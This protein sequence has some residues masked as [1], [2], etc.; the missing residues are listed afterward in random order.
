M[1]VL[2]FLERFL[3]TGGNDSEYYQ[4]LRAAISGAV[5]NDDDVAPTLSRFDGL[6]N[7]VYIMQTPNDNAHNQPSR[8]HQN[9]NLQQEQISQDLPRSPSSQSMT[10]NESVV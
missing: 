8:S 10:E 9:G 2:E 1:E 4:H 5:D 6:D 7:R 3:F